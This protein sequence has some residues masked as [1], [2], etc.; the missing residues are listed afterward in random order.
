LSFTALASVISTHLYSS[1]PPSWLFRWRTAANSG[2]AFA[3]GRG[4][5]LLKHQPSA[6]GIY[7]KGELNR[8]NVLL[9]VCTSVI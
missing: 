4:S 1:E 7:I 5:I 2:P 8:R 9:I 6:R 3:V